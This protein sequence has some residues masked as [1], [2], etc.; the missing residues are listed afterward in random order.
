M[1]QNWKTYKLGEISSTITY[2]YTESASLEEIG[3]KFLRITDIQNSFISWNNV[4]Y[5]PISNKDFEKYKL[6][7]GDIVIARTGNSTG[8][9]AII[10]DDINAVYASY[11][12]RYQI[13][14]N[15]ADPT[16]VAYNLRSKKWFD[17]VD[18]IKGGSAQPGANAQQFAQ[19]EITLPPLPEQ[20]AI[21]SI[22]SAL[23][24]KIELNLQQ[25]KTLEEMAMALYKH[26]FVDFG[27]FKDGNFIDSELGRIPE[28]WEVKSLGEII[29]I[30]H[31]F[32]FK[33][34][35]FVSEN[36][37]ELLLTPGNFSKNGGIQFNWS[38]QKFYSGKFPKEYCLKKGDLLIALT[39][40]TQSCEILGAPALIPDNDYNYLHNQRLGLVE[41]INKNYSN[42]I[43]YCLANTYEYREFIKNSK[44]GST[45][46]HSAPTRIY[47]YKIAYS[48]N[49][50]L[51]EIKDSLR[52]LL[53]QINFN[54][55]E[56]KLLTNHRDYL[57]P[58]LISGEIRVKDNDH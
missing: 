10:K 53:E 6:E 49:I 8:A 44:T 12:I 40:L 26:W 21:A 56:I 38:K 50:D 43:L 18:A 27:P 16:F 46:S 15:K 7:I 45:V 48:S 19:F 17:F 51:K 25:N 34:D 20:T 36:R 52:N 28:G 31:G 33:G 58:K 54:L 14:K 30:K 13:D 37:P 3:P 39:D 4:P 41:L 42:E 32:A 57:L 35:F 11:L 24:D 47:D 2:G 55:T 22:L 29:H 1:P 5:C 23:D 9:N